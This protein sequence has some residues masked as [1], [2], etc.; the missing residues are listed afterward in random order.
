MNVINMIDGISGAADLTTR[1]G[2]QGAGA[3]QIYSPPPHLMIFSTLTHTALLRHH[4]TAESSQPSTAHT[5]T[6]RNKPIIGS[7]LNFMCSMTMH[8]TYLH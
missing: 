8:E 4:H 2:V 7:W 1:A 3:A 6:L 5:E